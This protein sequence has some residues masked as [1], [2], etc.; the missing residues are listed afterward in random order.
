MRILS[1]LITKNEAGRYLEQTVHNLREHVDEL[2]V[3]DDRSDDNTVQILQD[4]KVNY[5]IRPSLELSFLENEAD[6]REQ[7]WERMENLLDPRHQDWVLSLDAD[8]VLRTSRNLHDICAEATQQG[9]GGLRMHIHEMWT[10]TQIRTD[11]WWD[12]T[13]GVRLS[14]YMPGSHFRS[15]ETHRFGGGSLPV[16][17]GPV[18]DLTEADILHYGY[19]RQEDR[20]AKYQRYKGRLGHNPRHIDSILA[21]PMLAELPQMV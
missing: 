6:F 19:T 17:T 10:P 12:Q 11:G 4:L 3:Y 16:F 18:A 21:T 2:I 5:F 9:H 20:E 7:A 14:E 13:T 8:E 1:Y 15:F